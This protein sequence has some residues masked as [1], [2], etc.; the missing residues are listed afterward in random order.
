MRSH[1]REVQITQ[2]TSGSSVTQDLNR[3]T[4]RSKRIQPEQFVA[5]NDVD[6]P[7]PANGQPGNDERWLRSVVENSS[8]IVTIVNPD[9]T[10]R[11]ASPAWEQVLGYVPI[12]AIGTLNV[13][14]HVHPDDLPHVLEETGK[15]LAE[16]AVATNEPS[17]AYAIRAARGGGWRAWAP[18]CLTP[19][20]EGRGGD[21]Q[22]RHR[23]QGGRGSARKVTISDSVATGYLGVATSG[24]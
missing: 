22:G 20:G 15:A 1:A 12:E 6:G 8:E 17:N 5:S 23:A 3:K 16:G 4:N 21:I 14:D 11:Y 10:L 7:T 2:R 24:V 18:T 13:P 19:G 9:G